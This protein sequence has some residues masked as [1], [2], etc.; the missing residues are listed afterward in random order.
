MS[1]FVI[2]YVVVGVLLSASY[3]WVTNDE[4]TLPVK[5]T[6]A[7][8]GLSWFPIVNLVVAFV[9]LFAF[10][11]AWFNDE[12]DN[13]RPKQIRNPFYRGEKK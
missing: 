12:F 7:V 9:A 10:M 8:L 11:H 3:F 13:G 2:A 4:E 6:V 1:L 5:D